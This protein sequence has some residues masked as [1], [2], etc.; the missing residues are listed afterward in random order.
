[1][2]NR[3][4]VELVFTAHPTESKRRTVLTKLRRLGDMLKAGEAQQPSSETLVA[5]IR[6]EIAT[7]WLTDRSRATQPAVT[8]EVK[9]GPGISQPRYGR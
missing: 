8:D 3:I 1:M 2:L 7:L 5:A 6:R 4:S 9:T